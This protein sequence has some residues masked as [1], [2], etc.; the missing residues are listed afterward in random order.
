LSTEDF[1]PLICR[2]IEMLIWQAKTWFELWSNWWEFKIK[3]IK[4]ILTKKYEK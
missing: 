1:S 4:N 2:W 3:E